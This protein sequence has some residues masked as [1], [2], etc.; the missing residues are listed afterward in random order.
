M[1]RF[2]RKDNIINIWISPYPAQAELT[3]KVVIVT[4]D[5]FSERK[6]E[7][8][9]LILFSHM[10]IFKIIKLAMLSSHLPF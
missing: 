2:A 9:I 8:G 3:L 10:V 4:N 5:L 6:K 7:R 1:D